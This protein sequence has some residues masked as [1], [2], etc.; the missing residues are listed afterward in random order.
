MSSSGMRIWDAKRGH[1]E[2]ALHGW[3]VAAAWN[4][5]GGA[6]AAVLIANTVAWLLIAR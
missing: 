5:A 2:F 1:S 4:P 3:W 6:L